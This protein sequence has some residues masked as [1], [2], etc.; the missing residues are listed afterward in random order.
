MAGNDRDVYISFVDLNDPIPRGR[1][2]FPDGTTFT[3][4]SEE[5]FVSITKTGTWDS[6]NRW[7]KFTFVPADFQNLTRDTRS[8]F[9]VDVIF[10]DTKRYTVLRGYLLISTSRGLNNPA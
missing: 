8:Y 2:V 7:V 5:G 9:E 1:Y 4:R 6:A 3:L 10:P